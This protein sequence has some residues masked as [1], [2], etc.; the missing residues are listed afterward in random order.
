[1]SERPPNVLVILSD[2]QRWDT[3]GSNGSASARTPHL[4]ALAERGVSF[5]ECHTPFP[6]C[7][8]S[9]TSLWT[10]RMPRN[11]HVM[12]NWRLLAP[13]LRETSVASAFVEAGFHTI[14][15][16][17]WHV[18]GTTP[19]R[20]GFLDTSAIPAIIDGRDRGRYIE[21]YREHVSKRGYEL[22]PG[23]LENLTEGDLALIDNRAGAPMCG[24]SAIGL[25]DYLET[26]QTDQF[27]AA[28]D[29]RPADRPFFAVCSYN[30]PHFPMVVPKPFDQV[31]DRAAVRLPASFATGPG[32]KPRE[33][34][35]S[36]FATDFAHLSE[37]GW[38]EV[39][40]H[41]QGFC[42]LIDS[43]VGQILGHLRRAGELERTIVVFTSDHG[44]MMGAHRLMEK[45]H[46]LHYDEATRVPLI[47]FHPDGASGRVAQLVSM[48]DIGATVAELAGVPYDSADGRSF[49]AMLSRREASIRDRVTTETCLYG[50]ESEASGQ[51]TDPAD[52]DLSRDALNLSV[53][54]RT[55]RYI[56]RSHDID[57][58]Y[59]HSTDPHD[60]LNVAADPSYA[61]E[62]AT[63]R[64]LL[65]E[66][67][68]DVFTEAAQILC[69]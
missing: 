29:R 43:Q 25:D 39:L 8:P 17:K 6:L 16:G 13:E 44:D 63:L 7:C 62:R 55:A 9:R 65:A 66:E 53:R 26:W 54:T 11:H 27:R 3:L 14:Y 38:I 61:G 35:E 4:D 69:A 10:G 5:E 32:T 41:Y 49:A 33:V 57:E 60:Q 22:V 50:M 40:A 2:E 42:S 52:L 19:E 24:A 12:G 46:F 58:L 45:G 18:P 31:I 64:K 20:M 21:P 28:L 30:A 51:Y 67:V 37:E 36:R 1:M 23:H 15:N 59:D 47:V 48:V 34:R 68:G 56:Y